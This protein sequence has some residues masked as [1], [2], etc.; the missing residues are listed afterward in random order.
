MQGQVHAC[1]RVA[2]GQEL[3]TLPLFTSTVIM[4]YL[5]YKA[6]ADTLNSG[7]H[8]KQTLKVYQEDSLAIVA[9][10]HEHAGSM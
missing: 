9:L 1:M 8:A 7:F 4:T 6:A 10:C 3:P 5:T 2:F